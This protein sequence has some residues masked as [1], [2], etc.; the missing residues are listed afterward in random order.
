MSPL[1]KQKHNKN[2]LTYITE[3][4]LSSC[5]YVDHS[6]QPANLLAISL[7]IFFC[8]FTFPSHLPHPPAFSGRSSNT[9]AGTCNQSLPLLVSSHIIL[10][11]ILAPIPIMLLCLWRVC[12][13]CL[14][15]LFIIHITAADLPFVVSFKKDGSYNWE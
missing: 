9:Q 7:H 5:S 6:T 14:C 13:P 8:Y 3:S 11:I 10:F 12:R 2:H 4:V 1:W 15:L